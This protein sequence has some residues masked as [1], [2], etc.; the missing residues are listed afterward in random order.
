[1]TLTESSGVAV[2]YADLSAEKQAELLGWIRS[3]QEKKRLIDKVILVQL[4]FPDGEPVNSEVHEMHTS[5]A[6][7]KNSER[8]PLYMASQKARAEKLVAWAQA[9][10]GAE[11]EAAR[12]FKALKE[13]A[14]EAATIDI[15]LPDSKQARE[16]LAYR[17]AHVAE[18]TP[19][20]PRI[21]RKPDVSYG[22]HDALWVQ[23]QHSGIGAIRHD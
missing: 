10:K 1:M 21:P 5:L 17:R 6:M 20:E 7:Q 16:L 2:P 3:E 9:V 15:P 18:V 4:Q 23:I 13:R 19:P 14:A 12:S 22:D 8:L 11:A